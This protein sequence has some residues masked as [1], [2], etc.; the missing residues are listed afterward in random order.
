MMS[1][2]ALVARRSWLTGSI[3]RRDNA[4]RSPTADA[5]EPA[6]H[7]VQ[8]AIERRLSTES[9]ACRRALFAEAGE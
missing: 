7:R 2:P 9:E 4:D 8:R 5:L 1:L 6:F 3:Q